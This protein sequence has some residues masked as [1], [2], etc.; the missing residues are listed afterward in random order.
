MND[1]TSLQ[2]AVITQLGYSWNNPCQDLVDTLEDIRNHG[3]DGGF[4]GFI[5]YTETSQFA[6]EHGKEIWAAVKS[7]SDDLGE[8]P[9]DLI[10]SFNCLNGL[11]DQDEILDTIWAMKN[12]ELEG[13]EDQADTSILNALAWFAAEEVAHQ[14]EGEIE[15]EEEEA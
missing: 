8:A 14:L 1:F 13:A 15:I 3:I 4:S 9:L 12:Y 10:Q 2:Q 11:Y 6:L 7:L 5:Y